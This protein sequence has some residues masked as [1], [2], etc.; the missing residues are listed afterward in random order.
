MHGPLDLEEAF[1][2]CKS[3]ERAPDFHDFWNEELQYE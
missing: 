1:E 3:L 2:R